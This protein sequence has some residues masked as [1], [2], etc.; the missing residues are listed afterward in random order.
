MVATVGLSDEERELAD[1]LCRRLAEKHA[2]GR[3]ARVEL[4]VEDLATVEVYVHIRVARGGD[5]GREP[6]GL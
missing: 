2:F 1:E 6:A 5:R 4:I 3:R